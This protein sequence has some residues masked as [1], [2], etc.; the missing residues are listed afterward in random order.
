MKSKYSRLYSI[1]HQINQEGGCISKDE[2]VKNFTKGK[3][4]KLSE[5][6]DH[7]F[8]ELERRMIQNAPFR[9]I[10]NNW[11][12]DPLDKTRK[13]IISQFRSI[14]RTA[15]AAIEWAEKYGVNDVK[16]K[17]NDYTGQELFK[18]LINAKKVKNDYIKSINK[19]LS[20]E[21]V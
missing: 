10:N 18:L 4:N 20:N 9:Q 2:I 6:S 7:E 5:L 17:F 3:T 21:R 13:A 12:N 1:I 16:K 8:R 11:Q 19:H 14:G 15:K